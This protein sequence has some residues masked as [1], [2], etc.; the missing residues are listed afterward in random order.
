VSVSGALVPA[1]ANFPLPDGRSTR[2]LTL[3]VDAER[4]RQRTITPSVGAVIGRSG[5]WI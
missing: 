1:P 3:P 5:S 2:R 4:T